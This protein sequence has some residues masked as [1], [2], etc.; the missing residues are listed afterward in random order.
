[1]KFFLSIGVI[2][3]SL[4]LAG[5]IE[6]KL[7]GNNDVQVNIFF[8][9]KAGEKDFHLGE[10]YEN[11]FGE[12]FVARNFKY[13]VSNIQL[14]DENGNYTKAAS[15]SFLIDEADSGSK[16]LVLSM[17]KNSYK[18]IKFLCG[19]DSIVNTSGVQTGS[20]DPAL[21][22][23]WTWNSGYIFAKLEGRSTT[24]KAP[25]HYFTYHIGGYK[26]GESAVR[27]IELDLD[28]NS[29]INI[30][31]IA[32]V[33]KWFNGQSQIKIS[34][35]PVCHSPGELAMKIADNY[36]MMFSISAPKK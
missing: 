5:F 35:S 10:N 1:M 16:H 21:G 29:S 14:L 23:F 12:N 24:S 11:A 8:H 3:S 28:K 31:I 2:I 9:H 36:S 22:M 7:P 18:K 27:I 4:F 33:Q 13:Y 25:G 6:R 19:V 34:D 32:D 15:G 17:P 20:L 30:H 26:D